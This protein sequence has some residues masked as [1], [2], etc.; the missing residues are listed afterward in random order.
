MLIQK[1]SFQ[2]SVNLGELY[3]AIKAS[4]VTSETGFNYLI[5]Y[6]FIGVLKITVL[7]IR[8]VKKFHPTRLI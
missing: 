8:H 4:E 2:F 1:E 3:I 6:I 7:T 5:I